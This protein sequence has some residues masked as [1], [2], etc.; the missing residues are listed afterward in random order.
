MNESREIR[1]MRTMAWEKAQGLL[2]SI[3][4]T[5]WSEGCNDNRFVEVSNMIEEF[6]TKMDN[7]GN[8][9]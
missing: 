5:Y 6:I 8:L 1:V 7:S 4:H 3:L 2:K 9:E